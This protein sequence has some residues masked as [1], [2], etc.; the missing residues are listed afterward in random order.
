[1]VVVPLTID[2]RVLGAL[3]FHFS[4]DRS[5]SQDDHGVIHALASQATQALER[6]RLSDAERGARLRAEIAEDRAQFL[7][8]ASAMLAEGLDYEATMQRVARLAVPDLADWCAVDVRD[9]ERIRRLAV[10]HSDPEKVELAHALNR[11]Y[12]PDPTRRQ[13][14]PEVLRTGQSELHEQITDEMLA[15]SID[16]PNVLEIARALGLRSVMIVPIITRGRTLGAITFVSAESMRRFGPEDLRM[17]EDLGR[18]AGAAMDNARLYEE[19]IDAIRL[20]DEFLS[21]AEHELRTPL[22]SALLQVQRAVARGDVGGLDR[23]VR[24]IRKLSAL[25]DRMLEASRLGSGRIE[26]RPEP[27]DLAVLVRDVIERF[28]PAR[29]TST[30]MLTVEGDVSGSW[31]REALEQLFSSL[32][33]NALKYGE[34]KPIEIVLTRNGERVIAVVQ[35]RGMGIAAADHDRI[36]RRFERAVSVRNFGGFGLGLWIARQIAAAHGGTIRVESEKGQGA[37][38]IVELPVATQVRVAG[39]A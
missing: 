11:E 31:D 27:T 34:G 35:D 28:N 25:I 16:D 26:V 8:D 15:A 5:L 30:M 17:A 36:F 20:R 1:M 6:S 13:G 24:S 10:A 23:A 7:A 14:V 3:S 32:I 22:T 9:E 21:V 29:A 39:A 38:L 19:A 18:R 12:P 33:D 37:R 4:A 2:E